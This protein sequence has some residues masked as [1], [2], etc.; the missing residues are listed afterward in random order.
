MSVGYVLQRLGFNVF[1]E[2]VYFLDFCVMF[3]TLFLGVNT[4]YICKCVFCIIMW[5]KKGKDLHTQQ[6]KRNHKQGIKLI[7][8]N[9]KKD[10]KPEK[11]T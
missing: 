8:S 10:V 3:R 4:L 1:V 6:K 5:G 9:D 7:E 11:I 2:T